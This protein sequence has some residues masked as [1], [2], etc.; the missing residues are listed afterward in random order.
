MFGGK[1][2]GSGS[3]LSTNEILEYNADSD[4]WTKMDSVLAEA[5]PIGKM[6][7]GAIIIN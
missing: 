5:G 3:V 1:D 4:T 7:S 2:K 6:T